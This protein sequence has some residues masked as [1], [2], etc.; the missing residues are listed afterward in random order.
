MCATGIVYVFSQKDA[1][2]V[3]SSLQKEDILAFPYHAH[4][5]PDVKSH[6]HC[7]WTLNK[8][9]VFDYYYY[10]FLLCLYLMYVFLTFDIQFNVLFKVLWSDH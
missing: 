10:Y 8:I 1:E 3:S 5:D 7:K 9:Q 2:N 6:V 4:M